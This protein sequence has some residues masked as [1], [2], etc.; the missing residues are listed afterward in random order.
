M[1]GL[2][3]I[4]VALAATTMM[5]VSRHETYSQAQLALLDPSTRAA[6]TCSGRGGTNAMR[7]ALLSAAAVV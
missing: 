5:G 2:K 6:D 1:H 3:A 4:A 7:A